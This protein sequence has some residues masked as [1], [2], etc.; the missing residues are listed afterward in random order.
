MT[1]C[2]VGGSFT[3]R[4]SLNNFSTLS[5]LWPDTIYEVIKTKY[6]PYNPL[7]VV[8]AKYPGIGS[9]KIKGNLLLTDNYQTPDS[10][11]NYGSINWGGSLAS[12][13]HY[14]DFNDKSKNFKIVDF[15]TPE[16]SL[17]SFIQS[18]DDPVVHAFNR[19]Y[20]YRGTK[21]RDTID[22]SSLPVDNLTFLPSISGG[23]GADTIIGSDRSDFISASTSRDICDFGSGTDLSKRVKDV[24]TGGSGIDIFYV[25]NGTKVTD[26]EVGETLHLYNDLS[27]DLRD[28]ID[29]TPIIKYKSTKTVIKLGDIRVVTNPVKYDYSYGFI[30][31][32]FEFCITDQNGTDC[33]GGMIPGQPE[34]YKFTAI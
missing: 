6:D 8:R 12:S 26:V 22:F 28:L 17:P 11:I 1:S 29:K 7:V 20:E 23:S 10:E 33:G 3:S 15:Y 2:L 19:G 18:F 27:N 24:L 4:G 5:L 25:D 14:K 13:L 30:D 16:K 34:G 21:K 9:F 32:E 31:S